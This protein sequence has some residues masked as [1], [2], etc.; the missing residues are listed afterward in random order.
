[1]AVSARP[2]LGTSQGPATSFQRLDLSSRKHASVSATLA[3]AVIALLSAGCDLIGRG[4]AGPVKSETR[5]AKAFT[6]IDVSGGINV[7]LSIGPLKPLE[8]SAQENILPLIAT[9]VEGDTLRIHSTGS[10]TSSA[11]VLV[12]I[13]TPSLSAVTSSG[14]SAM[15]IEG[16]QADTFD[17]NMS[18]GS[19]VTA[20]GTVKTVTIEAS[21]G[22]R[23]TLG[24]LAANGVTVDLSGGANGTVQA[25]AT[26]TGSASGGAQLTVL[27][28]ASVDVS[29][30]GGAGVTHG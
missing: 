21:G 14:G 18:G 26:L 8:V 4:G 13:V 3:L 5:E 12:T 25:S 7:N 1:M 15:T 24:E 22:A 17:L 19:G 20:K 30:S 10:Y 23:F 6:K 2:R 11:T 16:L 29:T 27:G 9:D 28:N